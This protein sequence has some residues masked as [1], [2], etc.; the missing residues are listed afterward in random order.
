MEV[1]SKDVKG[2]VYSLVDFNGKI[3]AGINNAV[4]DQ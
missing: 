4:S 2:G 1:V 3:L